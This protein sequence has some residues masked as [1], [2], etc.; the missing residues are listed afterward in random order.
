MN[1]CRT[2]LFLLFIYLA[3]HVSIADTLI[4]RQNDPRDKFYQVEDKHWQ[5]LKDP[6]GKLTFE[7]IQ[8]TTFQKLPRQQV[9]EKNEFIFSPDYNGVYWFKFTLMNQHKNKHWL[10]E[11]LDFNMK[12]VVVYA[13]DE[14]GQYTFTRAGI[15]FPFLQR[16]IVHKNLDFD[17]PYS[18]KAQVL[19]IKV[20]RGT[21]SVFPAV[22]K[23]YQAFIEY[24]TIE[25]YL[26]GLFYGII[27]VMGIYN[28]ILYVNMHEKHYLYYVFYVICVALSSMCHD[29]TAFQ[30]L[31]PEH[32][33]WNNYI[34]V[35]ALFGLVLWTL[36]YSKWFLNVKENAPAISKVMNRLIALT[37]VLLAIATVFSS[38]YMFYLIGLAVIPFTII[39]I[40][41]IKVFIKGF[42]PARFFL[43]AFSFFFL[44]YIIRTL[45]LFGIFMDSIFTVYSYN[46][47]VLVE[48]ILFSIAIGDRIK[49]LKQEK[50]K[51]LIEK[52]KA[53]LQMIQQLQENE[54]L[55]DKVN[56][57]LE[58]KVVQRT[59]EIKQKNQELEVANEQLKLLTDQVNQWN[60]K[61]DLDNRKLQTNIKEI[62]QARILLKDVK[63]DEFST[64]FPDERACLKYLSDLKWKDGYSC[65]KCSNPNFG[66]GKSLFGR[67]C[68][69]CNYDES[70]TNDTLFHRLRFPITKA[71]YM[72][73]LVSIKEKDITADELS[74]ILTLRRE[75]CWSFKR[76]IMTA[77]KNARKI[78]LADDADGWAALALISIN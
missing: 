32:P 78:P 52:E 61:L 26:L 14:N 45:T 4:I 68:T 70:P 41:A 16:D 28:L 36:F 12:E 21:S 60:I 15:S 33:E 75:T 23:S 13:P 20:L 65:K 6:S 18:N 51:A 22:I 25:Y 50:E 30:F 49:T 35:F 10:L 62:A 69:K 72:V 73:Y 59:Q 39:H 57:E 11:F 76:K 8:K 37:L 64:V 42:K 46:I 67:R 55:K 7:E 9:N 34:L 40:T 27:L 66:R 48:M 44:G 77:R 58:E 29:G 63:F 5:I 53:Q 1:P 74:E 71:F 31:F 43:M 54:K 47:G 19:Y 56:R 3:P 38:E 2:I 17:I 24:S